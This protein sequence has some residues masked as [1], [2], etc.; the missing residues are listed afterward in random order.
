MLMYLYCFL[1][2]F[3][4]GIAQGIAQT[5]NASAE[6]VAPLS[7]RV[8]DGYN[9]YSTYAS[10][11]YA[12]SYVFLHKL[13]IGSD[14]QVVK[15]CGVFLRRHVLASLLTTGLWWLAFFAHPFA[16]APLDLDYVMLQHGVLAALNLS[17]LSIPSAQIY[18]SSLQLTNQESKVLHRTFALLFVLVSAVKLALVLSLNPSAFLERVRSLNLT[19]IGGTATSGLTSLVLLT[20]LKCVRE[21]HYEVF[22]VGHRAFFVMLVVA[23]VVHSTD[24]AYFLLPAMFSFAAD[25]LYKFLHTTRCTSARI[26]LFHGADET[27]Y[28][29]IEAF[30]ASAIKTYPGCYFMVNFYN[31]SPTEWHPLSLVTENAGFYTFCAKNT[32]QRNAWT[33][34]L[35]AYRHFERDKW[36]RRFEREIYVQGPYGFVAIDYLSDKFTKILFVCS[37]LAILHLLSVFADIEAKQK[38]RHLRLL[39][40]VKVVWV[41]KQKTLYDKFKTLLH[42]LDDSLFSCAIYVTG[43]EEA[44]VAYECA[45][46]DRLEFRR[47]DVAA[48]VRQFA[49][50]AVKAECAVYVAGSSAIVGEAHDVSRELG[51]DF[52]CELTQ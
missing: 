4:R 48:L 14:R 40:S 27:E 50:S 46:A 36:R 17:L 43:A 33:N 13:R 29:V 15:T 49:K 10:C 32:G 37:G 3:A 41:L 35:S 42:E 24:S 23:C 25:F 18:S 12:V 19:S 21:K 28:A 38:T 8:T 11:I 5:Y 7:R 45:G 51:V 31:I 20:T 52:Y 1:S 47:P 16:V 9:L 22:Y 2:T 26:S 39:E 6:L 30:T 34:A 44:G